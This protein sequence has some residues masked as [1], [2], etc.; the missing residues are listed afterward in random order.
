MLDSTNKYELQLK[1]MRQCF[2]YMLG[3]VGVEKENV[4]KWLYE[5]LKISYE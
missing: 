5:K 3:K 4:P 1:N 2:G